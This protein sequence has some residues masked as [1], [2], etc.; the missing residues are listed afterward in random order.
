MALTLA[1]Q[2]GKSLSSNSTTTW[3]AY[4]TRMHFPCRSRVGQGAY[5]CHGSSPPGQQ[6]GERSALGKPAR[7]L[8]Y[9]SL[10]R[11]PG[12]SLALTAI[13]SL[14]NQILPSELPQ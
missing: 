3:D 1:T 13:L 7:V 6:S 4:S 8:A 11:P 14:D 10:S 9:S 5:A 12:T 2:Q